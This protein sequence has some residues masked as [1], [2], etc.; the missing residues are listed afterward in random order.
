MLIRLPVMELNVLQSDDNFMT[1]FIKRFSGPQRI[2]ENIGTDYMR[3]VAGLSGQELDDAAPM[4]FADELRNKHFYRYTC[5]S[6][7]L[8]PTERRTHY[9]LIY[10]TRNIAGVNKFTEAEKRCFPLMQTARLGARRRE[11]GAELQPYFSTDFEPTEDQ[12]CLQ[13]KQHYANSALAAIQAQRKSRPLA[14]EDVWEIASR[15]PLVWKSDVRQWLNT[16]KP[17]A[18]AASAA[19]LSSGR[20]S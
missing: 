10:G 12:Y 6:V 5:T 1:P 3:K 11:T 2:A 9:H 18:A 8:H 7:V 13:L 4:S 19:P 20:I 15:F 14:E 16:N 17:A